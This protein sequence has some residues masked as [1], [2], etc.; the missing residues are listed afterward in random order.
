VPSP[1]VEIVAIFIGEPIGI[2]MA[3]KNLSGDV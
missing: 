3:E 1:S 2:F